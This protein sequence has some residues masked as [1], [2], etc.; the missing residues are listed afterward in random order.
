MSFTA[1]IS[2]RKAWATIAERE[3]S[4]HS[5][6]RPFAHSPILRGDARH[7]RAA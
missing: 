1:V 7:E 2:Y 5:P 4:G 6:I 3:N